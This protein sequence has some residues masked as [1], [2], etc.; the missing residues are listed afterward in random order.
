MVQQSRGSYS[1]TYDPRGGLLVKSQYAFSFS[2][3]YQRWRNL[4]QTH[5][6][7]KSTRRKSTREDRMLLIGL[8]N[9]I[10]LAFNASTESL[11]IALNPLL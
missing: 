3:N 11:F 7:S 8:T 10:L 4:L 5:K 1:T 2:V 9:T 6:I